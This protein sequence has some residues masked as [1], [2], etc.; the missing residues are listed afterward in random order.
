MTGRI[1]LWWWQSSPTIG[2]HLGPWGRLQKWPDVQQRASQE[3]LQGE[4]LLSRDVME[5]GG[6][7]LW[8]FFRNQGT[9]LGFE[10]RSKPN[11]VIKV[12]TVE[13]TPWTM[14]AQDGTVRFLYL[15]AKTSPSFYPCHWVSNWVSEYFQICLLQL[16]HLPSFAILFL[17][18][19]FLLTFFY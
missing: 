8:K 11:I 5:H 2:W 6:T 17:R 1:Q 10:L 13:R 4:H 9:W 19:K 12:G 16:S 7:Y 3:V 14:R 15:A 18:Q